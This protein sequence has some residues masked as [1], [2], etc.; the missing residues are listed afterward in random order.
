MF[1]SSQ[2][3]ITIAKIMKLKDLNFKKNL[4]YASLGIIYFEM[5]KT[6]KWFETQKNVFKLWLENLRMFA[7]HDYM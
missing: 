1:D 7:F 5:K 2:Y 6:C 3:D 4:L